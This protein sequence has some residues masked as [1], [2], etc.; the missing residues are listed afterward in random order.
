MKTGKLPPLNAVRAFAAAARHASFTLAAAELGV[1]HGAVSRQVKQLEEH[2]GVALFVRGVRQITLTQAGR[3]LLA[4]VVPALERITASAAA[5][6]RARPA[7]TLRINVRPSFAVRWLIPQLPRFLRDYPGIEPQ[8][9]TSTL[10]PARLSRDS[11][12]IAIRRGRKGWPADLLPQPFL[13]DYACPVAAPA[14]LQSRP[15]KTAKELSDH[16]LLYCATRDGD[17]ESWLEMAGLPGLLPAGELRFEH[18]QFTLQAALDGLGVA[19]GPSALVAQDVAAGRLCVVLPE[20]ALPLEPWCFAL[21][22]QG[23]TAALTF[24][25]WIVARAPQ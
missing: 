2:L 10:D 12:D 19:L 5:V 25:R 21:P 22:D 15:I 6:A 20:P 16:V 13:P 4:G 7:Q 8:V 18:L 9:L 1:T 11:F 24:S 3:E 14:L 17:W 23:N